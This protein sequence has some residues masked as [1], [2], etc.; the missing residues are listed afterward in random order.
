MES[1][2]IECPYKENCVHYNTNK[3]IEYC[4][5]NEHKKCYIY[6]YKEILKGE[7]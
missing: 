5:T 7:G 2:N 6:I 3:S 1:Q 4:I